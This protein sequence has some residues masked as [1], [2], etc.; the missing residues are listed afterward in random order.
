MMITK[1]VARPMWRRVLD[2]LSRLHAGAPVRLEVLDGDNGI[3]SHGDDFRLVGLT[4][5]GR[6]GSEV[7]SAILARGAHL[8]HIIDQP[9]SMHLELLWES[10]TANV[11]IADAHGTRTLIH[12]GAPVFADKRRTAKASPPCRP[13]ESAA[14]QPTA[15]LVKVVSR[16]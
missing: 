6:E 14:G 1:E 3:H 16:A 12:L 4:S 11:Q 8:T 13:A 9:Q 15:A 2:D 10:R 5:D 7:I